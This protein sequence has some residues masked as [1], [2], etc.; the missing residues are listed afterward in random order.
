MV[1]DATPRDAVVP[2]RVLYTRGAE[3]RDLALLL[4]GDASPV[5][6]D[7][8]EACI[9]ARADMLVTSRIGS[10]DLVHVAA[11]T[12]FDK[13][14][15]GHVVA[16]I[17]TGPHSVL[18]ANVAH[19]IGSALGC[20][21]ELVTAARGSDTAASREVLEAMVAVRPG[22][23]WRVLTDAKPASLTAT[24]P[25]RSLIVAGA[26]GGNWFQRQLFG[27]G[28]KLRARASAGSVVVRSV[29]PRVFQVAGAPV[30]WVGP[31]LL[32]A[33][34]DA[35]VGDLVVP[36]VDQGL[37]VGVVRRSSLRAR[38]SGTV[39]DVME[40]APMV[41]M[42]DAATALDEVADFYEGAPIPIVDDDGRFAGS[43]VL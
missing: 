29:P 34:A 25:D 21:V 10:F 13:S 11:P 20:P 4:S 37:L 16:A 14:G 1:D 36:V 33:D 5:G 31:F 19:R 42:T 32:I 35:V 6:A 22:T 12:D 30:E 15:I 43:V 7:P 3:Q 9:A 18:A 27:P 8:V 28:A 40:P 23:T 26:P 41:R 39:Q 24:A 38:G 17:G 2:Q